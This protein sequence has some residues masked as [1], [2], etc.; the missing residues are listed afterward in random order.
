MVSEGGKRKLSCDVVLFGHLLNIDWLLIYNQR[1]MIPSLQTINLTRVWKSL[2]NSCLIRKKL[3]LLKQCATFD[4]SQ[5]IF[6]SAHLHWRTKSKTVLGW[7]YTLQVNAHCTPY[8]HDRQHGQK[9]VWWQVGRWATALSPSS[10]MTSLETVSQHFHLYHL[11]VSQY[12]QCKAGV[13]HE[14]PILPPPL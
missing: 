8:K 7:G 5:T 13:I 9:W 12:L 3:F 1:S 11:L 10:G 6:H 4:S 14:A 2:Q